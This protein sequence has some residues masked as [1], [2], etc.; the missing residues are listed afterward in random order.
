MTTNVPYRL[1]NPFLARQALNGLSIA[2]LGRRQRLADDCHWLFAISHWL[3]G[4]R[5]GL[6][7]NEYFGCLAICAPEKTQ[8]IIM[9][10]KKQAPV[11]KSDGAFK[12]DK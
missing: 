3:V 12:K 5:S 8:K 6:S 11:K 1:M 4:R 7:S 2:F 10:L 9:G